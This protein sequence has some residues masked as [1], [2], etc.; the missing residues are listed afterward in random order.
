MYSAWLYNSF[1]RQIL[2]LSD[3]TTWLYNHLSSGTGI[4]FQNEAK[5]HYV[6]NKCGCFSHF[7]WE[8]TFR[9]QV[10]EFKRDLGGV[11]RREGQCCGAWFGSH[12]HYIRYKADRT[13]AHISYKVKS[14][15]KHSRMTTGRC[16]CCNDRFVYYT[17]IEPDNWKN[18]H[19]YLSTLQYSACWI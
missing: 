2:R 11:S 13:C 8:W 15:E 17:L 6:T 7:K 9:A 3:L 1:D 14:D 10:D 12:G 18:K 16:V 5:R 4:C 19:K